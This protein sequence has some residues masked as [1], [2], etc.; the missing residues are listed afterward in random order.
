MRLATVQTE[1]QPDDH[2][3]PR[4]E[5][6]H[7]QLP[8]VVL[9]H[10]L[11]RQLFRG[12]ARILHQVADLRH[13]VGRVARRRAALPGPRREGLVDRNDV[14]GRA[15]VERQLLQGH[16]ALGGHLG[17]GGLPP[18][19]GHEEPLVDPDVVDLLPGRPREAD[20]AGLVVDRFG[21]LAPDPPQG[22]GGEAEVA[23]RVEPLGGAGEADDAVLAGV[24]ER[25]VGGRGLLDGPPGRRDDEAEVGLDERRLGPL[26]LADLPLEVGDGHAEGLGPLGEC[27]CTVDGGEDG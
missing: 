17:V 11:R 27:W 22:V 16:L 21:D 23:V 26:A 15:A 13:L 6:L 20:L 24:V 14:P 9:E 1:P 19:L 8:H 3:L 2:L 18:V 5:R 25:Q 4:A 10:L 12:G 7:H